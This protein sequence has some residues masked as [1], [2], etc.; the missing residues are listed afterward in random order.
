MGRRSSVALAARIGRSLSHRQSGGSVAAIHDR[1]KRTCWLCG[2]HVPLQEASRDH[3][4]PKSHGGYDKAS[5]YRLAHRMCNAARGNLPYEL[6]I[7]VQRAQPDD[8]KPQVVRDALRA[9]LREY[10]RTTPQPPQNV[11]RE[12]RPIDPIDAELAALMRARQRR[13]RWERHK[14]PNQRRLDQL[15]DGFARR[16]GRRR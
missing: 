9:A 11:W 5:N 7:E 3:Q 8:A 15:L 16:K 4:R 10:H 1:D 6:V 13:E 14:T 12:E 2:W